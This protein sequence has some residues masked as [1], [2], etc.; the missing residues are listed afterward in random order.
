MTLVCEAFGAQLGAQSLPQRRNPL[1]A[2]CVVF[3]GDR[4]ERF[5]PKARDWMNDNAWIVN[6]LVLLLSSQS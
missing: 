6:E 2:L 1:T 5:L 3:M 4:A